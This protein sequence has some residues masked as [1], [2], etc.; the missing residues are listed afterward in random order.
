VFLNDIN[1]SS[2]EAHKLMP[3]A[4]TLIAHMEQNTSKQMTI[5]Q[6]NWNN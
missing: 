3:K 4:K 2:A 1:G 5:M 6:N